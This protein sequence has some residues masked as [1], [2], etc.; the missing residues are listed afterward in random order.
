MRRLYSRS[1][2]LLAAQARAF[3]HAEPTAAAGIQANPT[4][5]E[6]DRPSACQKAELTP[7]EAKEEL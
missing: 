5:A 2:K 7:H 4:Q 6:G 3:I 1:P